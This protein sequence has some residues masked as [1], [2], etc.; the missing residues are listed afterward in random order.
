M[1]TKKTRVLILVIL[2]IAPY[3]SQPSAQD[4]LSDADKAAIKKVTEHAMAL[5]NAPTKDWAAYV[6]AY[7]APDAIVLPPNAA[8][9]KGQEALTSFFTSFPPLSNMRFEQLEVDGAG[10]LAYVWGTYSLDMLPPGAESPIN[11]SGKFIEIWRT[12]EDGSWRVT[13]DIFNSDLPL[14]EAETTQAE[15]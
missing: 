1:Y 9:V 8:A 12:Q 2:L 15:K 13:L 10:G 5:A 6:K 7:Y 14:P 4:S 3:C 11:D